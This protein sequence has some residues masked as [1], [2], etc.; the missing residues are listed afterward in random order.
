MA[1]R[2]SHFLDTFRN[3]WQAGTDARLIVE[4][5]AGHA[6]VS[7]HQPLG[8]CP[9]LHKQQHRRQPGPSRL[10][11]RAR[12]AAASAAAVNASNANSFSAIPAADKAANGSTLTNVTDADEATTIPSINTAEAA[13][14]TE[15]TSTDTAVKADVPLQAEQA[16]PPLPDVFCPDR[17]YSQHQDQIP[18]LDGCLPDTFSPPHHQCENCHQIFGTKEQLCMH[19]EAHEYGCDDC[20]ICHTSKHLT[21]MLELECHPGTYYAL[22][23]IRPATLREFASTKK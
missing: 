23:H 22:H 7:L 8:I 19:Q 16:V 3:T 2:L 10:R 17:D 12:R 20:R 9:P 5:H 14:Q 13:V 18:Q 6:W 4:C 15:S 1:D 21:D 11:R